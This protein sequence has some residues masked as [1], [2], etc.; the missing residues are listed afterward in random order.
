MPQFNTDMR[1]GLLVMDR[2][3]RS[4]IR[5]T[6]QMELREIEINDAEDSEA[7][8]YINQLTSPYICKGR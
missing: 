3:I 5:I 8:P 6:I 7:K 1:S 4:R 2:N